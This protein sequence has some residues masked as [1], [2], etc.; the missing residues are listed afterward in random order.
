MGYR[1][2]IIAA[3]LILAP[4]AAAAG[5]TGI[6]D[7]TLYD[8]T[9]HRPAAGVLI[10]ASSPA[11]IESV[12]TDSSGRFLFISLTPGLYYVGAD[13]D[14]PGASPWRCAYASADAVTRTNLTFSEYVHS[15]HRCVANANAVAP[16][17]TGDV[18]SIF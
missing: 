12:R 15:D 7:G 6:I 1:V 13:L 5:T 8:E 10:T 17:T 3:A 14:F 11:Q 9:T 4:I 2:A 16:A 18:Y